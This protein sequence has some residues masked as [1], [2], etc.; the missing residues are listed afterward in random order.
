MRADW[1]AFGVF[2]LWGCDPDAKLCHE[3]MQSAQALVTQVDGKSASSVEQS[4]AAVTQ[5]HAACEKANLVGER[6]QLLKAQR[7]LKAQLDLLE[8]RAN[9]KKLEAP[10]PDELARLAKNGDPNCPKG[11]A[12]KPKDAKS[13]VRCTGPQL[14]DM[15]ASALKSYYGD[16]H[17][18][19]TSQESPAEVRAEHGAELYV[20]SFDKLTDASARCVTAYCPTGMSWQ[21]VTARLTGTPPEKLKLD[22]PVKSVRGELAVKVEHAEDQPTIHLGQCGSVASSPVSPP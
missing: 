9:R 18:K 6:D 1:L 17:F 20:F 12:Y 4:L 19:V 7:E 13:E 21:E 22:Q 14:V 16:R 2:G 5:A 8:Q 10:S 15:P 11:Q 3:R